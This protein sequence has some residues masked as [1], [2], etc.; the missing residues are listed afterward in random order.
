MGWF[1]SKRVTAAQDRDAKRPK[2]TPAASAQPVYDPYLYAPIPRHQQVRGQAV[3]NLPGWKAA[4][5]VDYAEAG[6]L[7]GKAGRKVARKW[8]VDASL[9]ARYL[10]HTKARALY[11]KRLGLCGR[12]C[13]LRRR[14]EITQLISDALIKDNEQSYEELA[15]AVGKKTTSVWRAFQTLQVKL[16]ISYKQ[17]GKTV[18]Q[19]IDQLAW[20]V[21]MLTNKDPNGL[22]LIDQQYRACQDETCHFASRVRQLKK[23]LPGIA[24]NLRWG[25]RRFPP[26]CM[27]SAVSGI[28]FF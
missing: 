20:A 4:I 5:D 27:Y 16:Y 12:L 11:V 2:P 17:P 23:L 8:E 19:I 9:P 14:P 25:H 3:D 13:L 1:K 24:K 6:R 21:Q 10:K 18:Q 22:K 7:A 28:P 15:K 26:K